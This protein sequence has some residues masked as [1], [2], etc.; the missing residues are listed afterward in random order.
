MSKETGGQA[1]PRQ[2][3]GYDGRDN[4]IQYQEDGMT[5][6]DYF[7]ARAMQ[8]ILSNPG[9]LEYVSDGSVK[10]VVRDAYKFADAML[11]GR[12]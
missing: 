9:Q 8:G 2:D 3:Y 1:F 10:E 4:L 11:E 12:E 7:A 6:R 5:L